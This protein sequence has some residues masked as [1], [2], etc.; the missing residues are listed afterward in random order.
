MDVIFDSIVH[1]MTPYQIK[2]KY[3][4]KYNTVRWIVNKYKLN[5]RVNIKKKVCGFVK[6][7]SS[8]IDA[9]FNE[10]GASCS[11]STDGTACSNVNQIEAEEQ[12]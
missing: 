5:A 10:S 11:M 6:N 12:I 2:D 1:K 4:M 7:N 3:D 9:E 8:K